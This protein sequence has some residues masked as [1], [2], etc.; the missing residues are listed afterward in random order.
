MVVCSVL[1]VF[2]R[3]RKLAR[4]ESRMMHHRGNFRFEK[5][6]VLRD[7]VGVPNGVVRALAARL[8][9]VLLVFLVVVLVLAIVLRVCVC[10]T[11]RKYLPL[12]NEV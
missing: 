9:I 5:V 10:K 3:R 1:I 12:H 7:A 4:S 11:R 6:V 2:V 8:G